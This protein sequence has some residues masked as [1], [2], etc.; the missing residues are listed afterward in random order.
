MLLRL[1]NRLLLFQ[2]M[3]VLSSCLIKSFLKPPR[4]KKYKFLHVGSVQV[5][6]KPLTRL[7]I[8]AS[9][10][11][12]LGDAR[13][14]KFKTSILGMIQSSVYASP[15]HFD[16]FPNLSVSGPVN[17]PTHSTAHSIPARLSSTRAR[18]RHCTSS[19]V[20]FETRSIS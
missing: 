6:V 1:L 14:L 9:V 20:T 5:V 7:G 13:F 17:E 18:T 15:I 4:L 16:V 3:N 12:C 11:L 2:E 8:Y 10:L 19:L